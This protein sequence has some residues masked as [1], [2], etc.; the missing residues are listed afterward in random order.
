MSMSWPASVPPMFEAARALFEGIGCERSIAEAAYWIERSAESGVVKAIGA[1]YLS[2]TC[3][4][5]ATRRR[6]S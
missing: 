6:S 2:Y 5:S 3:G 4:T 1:W